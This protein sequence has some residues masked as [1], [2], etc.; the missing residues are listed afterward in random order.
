M[1][2][3]R[4]S[5]A[6]WHDPTAGIDCTRGRSGGGRADARGRPSV[7][8]RTSPTSFR[9]RDRDIK[10]IFLTFFISPKGILKSF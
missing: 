5:G 4:R 1:D 6:I 9:S 2:G 10:T 3:G 8:R 7:E